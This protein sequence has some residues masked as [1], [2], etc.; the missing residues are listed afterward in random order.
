M[1]LGF[2]DFLVLN[3]LYFNYILYTNETNK[4]YFVL[5]DV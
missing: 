5:L 2:Y 1:K 4:Y 3:F